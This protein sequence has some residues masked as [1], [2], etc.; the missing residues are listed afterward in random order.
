[1]CLRRPT[2]N[3]PTKLPINF[4]R[5]LRDYRVIGVERDVDKRRVPS[6]P[7]IQREFRFDA[8]MMCRPVCPLSG[9]DVSPYT[10]P[11]GVFDMYTKPR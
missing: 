10:W 2:G 8:D 11:P 7:E 5:L 9:I 4:C 6:R 1:M 3:R